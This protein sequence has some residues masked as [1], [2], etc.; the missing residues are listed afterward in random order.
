MLLTG[1]L[2]T[3]ALAVTA[4]QPDLLQHQQRPEDTRH[5]VATDEYLRPAVPG[6]EASVVEVDTT[7]IWFHIR[8]G[9]LTQ[10][11]AEFNRLQAANPGWQPDSDLRAALQN[12][13]APTSTTDPYE[14]E[15]GRLARM[16]ETQVRALP[17]ARLSAA[18]S[19]TASRQHANNA[20]L[21]GWLYLQRHEP[22]EALPLFQ[23]AASWQPGQGAEDG[24]AEAHF[25]LAQQAATGQQPELAL[26]QAGLSRQHGRATAYADL[27]W[28][29]YDQ[30]HFVAA[31]FA[32]EQPPATENS[33]YGQLLTLQAQ[34][35]YEQA[36]TLAC[37]E[38]GR[39]QRIAGICDDLGPMLAWAAFEAADYRQA[40]DRFDPLLTADPGNEGYAF[41]LEESLRRLNATARLA[42]ARQR[43]PLLRESVSRLAFDR[44]WGRKQFDLAQRMMPAPALAGRD[45]WQLTLGLQGRIK[46]GDKGLTRL[47]HY[48]PYVAATR[49]WDEVRLGVALRMDELNSGRPPLDADFGTQPDQAPQ[50][51]ALADT[52]SFSPEIS[53]R[54]ERD[55]LTLQGSFFTIQQGEAK[56]SQAYGQLQGDW[57]PALGLV[58]L[59]LFRQPLEDSLLARQGA[60]DPASDRE[61]GQVADQGGRLLLAIPVAEK[62]GVAVSGTLASQQ[63][64]RVADNDRKA[65]RLDLAHDF[66]DRFS[67]PEL[68]YLRLGPFI[69]W[70]SWDQNLS[71]FTYGH[72]GYYSPQQ[73]LR[74]G[75]QLELLT[76]E[77]R[78]WQVRSRVSLA[79]NRVK[80]DAADFYPLDASGVSYDANSSRGLGGDLMLEGMRLVNQQL[81]VGGYLG[82]AAADDYRDAR[83][84]LV[85][86]VPL[87]SRHSVIS[88]D[89]P[90]SRVAGH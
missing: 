22:V 55:G 37:T 17:A 42:E 57:Y 89:L 75:L 51:R 33:I 66:A 86:R 14:L 3:Q 18:A 21:L 48:Q 30:Q 72:G 28:L 1:L 40:A 83:F 12:R 77:A 69:E 9:Q 27:G 49:V 45:D 31:Q 35:Q 20:L 5:Q 56:S 59:T 88:A 34:Q 46:Q 32:F 78:T 10:A 29:L 71:H 39:S 25:R 23:Q 26:Q 38:R 50:R 54:H 15:M 53:A 7:G 70:M 6:A 84:G 76:A 64:Q 67:E 43:H 11:R 85:V 80:E 82:Y 52:R 60:K 16:S 41:A 63:G 4:A 8:H 13:P 58:S 87:Q 73:L 62:T 90:L 61:W 24:L 79:W 65:L 74:T 19:E 2:L 81:L 47:T 44:A 68:D 36:E